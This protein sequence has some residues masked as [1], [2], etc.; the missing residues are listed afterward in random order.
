M[1][2][3]YRGYP[4][5]NLSRR[6]KLRFLGFRKEQAGRLDFS[7]NN[8]WVYFWAN[9]LQHEHVVFHYSMRRDSRSD[10]YRV[11]EGGLMSVGSLCGMYLGE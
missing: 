11:D 4:N 3:C 9:K 5:S 6:S 7:L 8:Y 10:Y 2:T 1:K